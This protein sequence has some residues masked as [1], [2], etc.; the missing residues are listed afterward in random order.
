MLRQIGLGSPEELFHSIPEDLLLRR[1]LNTPAA[2]SEIELLDRKS[3]RLNSSHSQISYAVFCLKKNNICTR[4][5]QAVCLHGERSLLMAKAAALHRRLGESRW[6][7]V[8]G[9]TAH[10]DPTASRPIA[11]CVMS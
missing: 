10:V 3:R 1:H 11:L 4:N 8:R 7:S 9:Q 6:V 2:L 5:G